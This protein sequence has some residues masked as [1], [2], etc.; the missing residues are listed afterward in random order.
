LPIDSIVYLAGIYTNITNV[1]CRNFERYPE[2]YGK[3]SKRIWPGFYQSSIQQVI[4]LFS[5]SIKIIYMPA[6]L[7]SW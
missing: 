7:R 5:S 6:Y 3:L 1:S 2:Y 4:K